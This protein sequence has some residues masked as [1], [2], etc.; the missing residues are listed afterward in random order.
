MNDSNRRPRRDRVP[1]HPGRSQ[2][3]LPAGTIRKLWVGEGGVLREHLLRLD[4]ESRRYRF[5]SPVNNFFI[6]QYAARAVSPETIVHGFFVD[7]VLRA[8]AE[9]RPYTKPFAREAEA[10][11]SVERDWQDRGIGSELMERTVLAARNRGIGTIYMNCLAENRRM[12]AVA[13]KSEARLR[14]QADDVVGKLDNK[15][16]TP[17]SVM[18][19]FIA[20]G[21]GVANVVLDLQSRM[22]RIA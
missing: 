14:L 6:E 13:R 18:R 11:F 4:S 20:D 21:A 22:L 3:E 17:L 1:V 2:N 5:G 7:N 16:A 9:L 19:E 15:G 8:A 10:A 12:Q